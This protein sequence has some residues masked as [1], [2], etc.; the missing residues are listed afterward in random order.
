M[1]PKFT[2]HAC[3]WVRAGVTSGK[4]QWVAGIQWMC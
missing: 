2:R 3:Y 4:L 1:L